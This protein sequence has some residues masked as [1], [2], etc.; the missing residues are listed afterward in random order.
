MVV[1]RYEISNLVFNSKRNS[2]PRRVHILF[3]IYHM[4]QIDSM[5]PWVCLV[6]NHKRRQDVVR[7]SVTQ[8]AA[9]RWSLC[10]S[11]HSLTSSVIYY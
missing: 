9:P 7:T 2:I 1:C 6:I 10:C 3:S 11:Y 8:T 5:L 4:K